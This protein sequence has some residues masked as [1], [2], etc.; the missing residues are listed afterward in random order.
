MPCLQHLRLRGRMA[1][2]FAQGAG[3][4]HPRLTLEFENETEYIPIACCMDMLFG[5]RHRGLG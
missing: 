4:P 5:D 1:A 3:I 2:N